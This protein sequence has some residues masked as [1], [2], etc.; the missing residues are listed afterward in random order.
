MPAVLGSPPRS[1]FVGLFL[2][3]HD[4]DALMGKGGVGRSP[5]RRP[6]DHDQALVDLIGTG[7]AEVV[8]GQAAGRGPGRQEWYDRR[9]SHSVP[10]GA[11]G[12]DSP[13]RPDYPA[14]GATD[15]LIE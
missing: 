5:V 2:P 15:C 3:L 11:R 6:V 14:G 4:P 12:R 1:G 8:V 9:V 10:W 13:G 7:C